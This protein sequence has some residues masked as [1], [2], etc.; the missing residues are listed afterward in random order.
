MEPVLRPGLAT[1]RADAPAMEGQ[2]HVRVDSTGAGTLAGAVA[3][4][5]VAATDYLRTRPPASADPP[6]RHKA[7]YFPK[8]GTRTCAG[9]NALIKYNATT[10]QSGTRPTVSADAPTL[11]TPTRSESAAVSAAAD[12]PTVCPAST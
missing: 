9:A 5:N 6:V 1:L 3:D 11:A 4:P 2:E 8:Y 7:V 12:P 10:P